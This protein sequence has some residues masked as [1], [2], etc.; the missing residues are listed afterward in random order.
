MANKTAEIYNYIANL[1]QNELKY[2]A[3]KLEKKRKIYSFAYKFFTIFAI[4]ATTGIIIGLLNIPY[5]NPNY[6]IIMSDYNIIIFIGGIV[7]SAISIIW[8]IR[9]VIFNHYAQE[10][11]KKL[12]K[13]LY[14]ALDKNLTYIP[15][16]FKLPVCFFGIEQLFDL[17]PNKT[18]TTFLLEQTIRKLHV[19]PNYDYIKIDDVILGNYNG[20]EVQI[21]EFNLIDKQVYRDSKGNRRE[22]Y[23]EVFH[24]ALFQTSME[25]KIKTNIFIKQ[26]NSN[27]VCPNGLQEVKLESNEFEKIYSVY[28]NDQIEAR[29]FLT[30]TT[31]DNFI[32]FKQAGQR[33]SGYINGKSVN[34]LIHASKDMFEP[35]INKPV[36]NPNNY[37]DIIFQAKMILD[38][39]TDLK[40]ESKTG[41]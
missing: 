1:Y 13:K 20:R 29:Y 17:F 18:S 14:Q 4:L 11:K 34:L 19:F 30:T 23:V 41:L 8:G 28:S 26:K 31:M 5:D 15:G 3:E 40:L 36:N 22:K 6:Q 37:F 24:G 39:I 21:I 7:I 35:D 25:K 16:K 32:K 10:V 27:L 9:T 33:I 2:T 38:I 12:F